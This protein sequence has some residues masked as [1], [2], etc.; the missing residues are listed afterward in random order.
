MRKDYRGENKNISKLQ[1]ECDS[2]SVTF[3]VLRNKVGLDASSFESE[4]CPVQD[5]VRINLYI[6]I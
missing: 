6:K 2:L 4:G 3:M 5:D 1:N